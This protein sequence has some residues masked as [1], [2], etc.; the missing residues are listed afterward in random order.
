MT[1]E[2]A[3]AI[4]QN[5]VY[6]TEQVLLSTEKIS[7]S[8]KHL[9]ENN[10]LNCDSIYVY[11][12]MIVKNN[13]EVLGCA[14]A[15]EPF[16]F[17]EKGRYYSPYTYREN[18]SLISLNLGNE[19]YEYFVMDW[20]LIPA[21]IGKAYWTEPY[22]DT[23]GSEALITTYSIPFYKTVG[24]EKKLAGTITID[25]SLEWLTDIVSSVHVLESGYASVITRNGTFV[26]HPNKSLIMNQTIFSYATELGSPEL[27]TIGRDMQAGN[28]D[29]V[30]ICLGEVDWFISYTPLSLSNWSLAVV[31]PQDEM[32]A[33][34]K[35]ITRVL[36]FIIVI[37]LILLTIIVVKIVTKQISPLSLFA[38]SAQEV[39]AGNFNAQLPQISSQDE[40]KDLH[41]S[42]AQMQ[43]DLK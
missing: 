43:K 20:Y 32:Y 1:L 36:V 33:P 11:T 30:S 12:Q 22:F 5:T 23:G 4:S 41:T 16:Y 37:G 19:D 40:M 13:P 38:I 34:L 3:I 42:F 10:Q 28:T 15:F 9:F 27:R 8:Y 21:T 31:F 35:T 6:K 39:A 26:T 25:L 14:I 29:F 18:D 24:N 2:N 17:P 7:Q